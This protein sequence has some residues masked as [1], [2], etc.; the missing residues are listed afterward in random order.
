M[1]STLLKVPFVDLQLQHQAIQQ[2]IDRAIEKV[3]QRG[4]FILGQ[5]LAEFEAS[6]ASA[7]GVKFAVGVASGTSAIALGLQ[8]CGIGVGDE[9]LIP[10][11]TFIATVIGTI[12]AGATPILVDCEPNTALIDLEAAS[13]V[14]TSKTKAIIPVHL[15]GQMVAP[16][17]LIDF[18]TTHQ[19]IIF[20]DAAQAHLAARDGY[21]AGAIGLAAGFSF[22]PSKNLGAF[23]SGG[24]VTTNEE[25][26]A[27][28]VY[29]LRNYGAPH[30]YFHTEVGTN[31]RLDTL[32]AAILQ[33]KLAHLSHWNSKRN[34]VAQD[35]DILFEPLRSRGII[36]LENQSGQGHVY[37]LYVI[38]LGE[39]LGK[40]RE[41]I[42]QKLATQGIQTGIHYPLP[43]HLQPAYRYLGYQPGDFPQAE[44]M[45]EEILSLPMYPE[46]SKN[47][48]EFLSEQL[49]LVTASF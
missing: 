26:I 37:H 29:R 28:K 43:C 27:E 24:I 39:F 1:T 31:S 22:Y 13:K 23:G 40:H 11:N 12:Q 3:I 10:T 18:A 16:S 32:Q 41:A 33:V 17:K 30:K 46:L 5:A 20:E 42:Q 48:I 49:S 8:A 6:F 15:Y 34:Q 2:E 14:I 36:P 35:Y 9:V 7:C 21:R 25:V 45:C 38:R 19:L 44:R 47:Q 4:D